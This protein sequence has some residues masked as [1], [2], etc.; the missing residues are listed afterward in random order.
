QP[1]LDALVSGSQGSATG[2]TDAGGSGGSSATST[3]TSSAGAAGDS[4]STTGSAGAM[5][6]DACEDKKRNG[7]ETD[8]DCG[9][10]SDCERCELGDRCIEDSDCFSAYCAANVCEEPSCNDDIQNQNETGIDCGGACV[11]AK[12]CDLGFGCNLDRDCSSG[13]CTDGTCVEHCESEKKDVDE[14]D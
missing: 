14:T 1:D 9:G 7:R 4:S 12:R 3:S 10:S 6:V 2:G 8:V 5:P 13:A 11:P